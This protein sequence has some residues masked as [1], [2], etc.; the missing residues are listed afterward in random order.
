MPD[1]SPDAGWSMPVDIVEALVSAQVAAANWDNFSTPPPGASA[2][3]NPGR[4][5][6]YF[7]STILC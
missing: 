7:Y 4:A 3:M 6:C 1:V 5:L 2:G